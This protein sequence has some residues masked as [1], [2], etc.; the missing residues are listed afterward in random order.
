M[1]LSFRAAVVV[2]LI[3][4]IAFIE[5]AR[6]TTYGCQKFQPE[7]LFLE[8]ADRPQFEKLARELKDF[9]VPLENIKASGIENNQLVTDCYLVDDLCFHIY[10]RTKIISPVPAI[11]LKI[12]KANKRLVRN[13]PKCPAVPKALVAPGVYK[14]EHPHRPIEQRTLPPDSVFTE[15]TERQVSEIEI[16]PDRKVV[17]HRFKRGKGTYTMAYKVVG[18]ELKFL[19]MATIRKNLG[20]L[21]RCYESALKAVPD[22]S[23]QLTMKWEVL[24]TGKTQQVKV[25]A[26]TMK[27]DKAN[28]VADFHGC[29]VTEIGKWQ[30]APHDGDDTDSVEYPFVFNPL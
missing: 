6:A 30:Y 13:D 24:S 12:D 4:G 27:P 25:A 20:T 1:R 28:V 5:S 18:S 3:A 16:S 29:I 9:Y 15:Q 7:T 26:S 10:Q 11:V 14:T 2:F 19:D 22:F 23:G 21:R 17:F 8:P